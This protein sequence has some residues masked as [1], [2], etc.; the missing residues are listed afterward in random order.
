M[1]WLIPGRLKSARFNVEANNEH[2]GQ[3]LTP[4]TWKLNQIVEYGLTWA[5]DNDCF[6][7]KFN[8]DKFLDWLEVAKP[9]QDRC[10]FISCP[11]V[12]CDPVTTCRQFSAWHPVI[13]NLGYKPALVLQDGIQSNQI[14][15]ENLSTVFVGGSTEWKLSQ[16][17]IKLLVEAGERGKWRHIGRINSLQRMNHF[18]NYADSFDGT[19][20]VYHPEGAVKMYLPKIRNKKLQFSF[21]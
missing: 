10:L 3:L 18:W 12:V 2:I 9:Y 17:V 13:K 8:T 6:K 19:D 7:G 14:D 15:W 4:R 1:L 21:K 11:D 16:D 5:G 20:Y